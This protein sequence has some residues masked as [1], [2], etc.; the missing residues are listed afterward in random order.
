[1]LLLKRAFEGNCVVLPYN[2]RDHTGFAIFNEKEENVAFSYDEYQQ[3]C[4]DFE[5]EWTGVDDIDQLYGMT[6][7]SPCIEI[8]QEENFSITCRITSES[9]EIIC[10]VFNDHNGYY[11]HDVTILENGTMVH[12]LCV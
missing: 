11:A 6:F 10:S 1:M 12:D 8:K 4:E 5:V 2:F 7:N 9:K 3:C